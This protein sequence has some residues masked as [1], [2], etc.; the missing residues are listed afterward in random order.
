MSRSSMNACSAMPRCSSG[1][2]PS[3]RAGRPCNPRSTSPPAVSSPSCTRPAA[4]A[5][6]VPMPCSPATAA[7]GRRS[8]G[9]RNDERPGA[10][11]F[12]ANALRST[13]TNLDGAQ[14]MKRW[15]MNP[16]AGSIV[17]A[18]ERDA[19]GS[20]AAAPRPATSTSCASTRS[21][22]CR[23]M[24][25]RRRIRVTPARRWPGPG[26]LTRSGSAA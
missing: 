10:S 14:D 19:A 23:W 20:G 12:V 5:P 24:R 11:L 17:Q 13:A 16:A 15:L 8:T 18:A 2:T 6:R 1:P 22:P 7:P 25:S 9:P 3:R 4:R 21:G 26:S